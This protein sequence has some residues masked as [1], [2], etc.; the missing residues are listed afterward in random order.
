MIQRFKP[1]ALALLVSAV[2]TTTLAYA[3][4]EDAPAIDKA[5]VIRY[6]TELTE[7][8]KAVKSLVGT[9]DKLAGTVNIEGL[10]S[11]ID[12][13]TYLNKIA[14]LILKPEYR[15]Q[16]T[17]AQK[18]TYLKLAKTHF[19]ITMAIG[20]EATGSIDGL[21]YNVEGIEQKT[22]A[23]GQVYHLVRTSVKSAEVGNDA[24][25]LLLVIHVDSQGRYSMYDSL[26]AGISITTG[27]RSSYNG[28]V[29]RSGVDGLNEQLV[30]YIERQDSGYC[31]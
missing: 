24:V 22:N 6:T 9:R 25:D 19:A 12:N 26:S 28:A 2:Q 30:T 5:A 13:H 10:C 7:K 23:A 11:L 4:P 15:E 1:A 14:F 27:P 16:M 31:E 3:R 29:A 17:S 20:L 21:K 18:Q 8:L